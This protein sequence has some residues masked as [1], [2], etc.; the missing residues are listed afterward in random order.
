MKYIFFALIIFCFSSCKRVDPNKKPERKIFV[1]KVLIAKN[2]EYEEQT[3]YALAFNDGTT[4]YTGFGFY[5]CLL[6][7]D[8]VP[9]QK[10]SYY[11]TMKP[12]CH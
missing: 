5:S 3:H 6:I 11:F 4:E 10:I 1:Y 2:I 9:F 12:E 8:T 7:G